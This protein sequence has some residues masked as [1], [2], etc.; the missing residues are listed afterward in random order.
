[1]TFE[2][3]LDTCV[4]D[5][6]TLCDTL[7]RI[8]ENGA[9]EPRWSAHVLVELTRN[10]V[11]I[12]SV[13]REGA[14]ARIT[15]MTHAFPNATVTAYA[16]LLDDVPGHPDDAHVMAAS[17]VSRC[18][19]IVTANLKDFPEP[20]LGQWGLTVSHP[21]A[22]LLDQLELHPRETLLALQNQSRESSRP[23]TVVTPAVGIAQTD[24]RPPIRCGGRTPT[25]PRSSR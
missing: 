2:I 8:A 16:Q 9:F 17:I 23:V 10:L 25:K 6:A 24:R 21:D 22:F 18:Q 5:P 19:V 4:L 20:D 13:G 15:A 14:Q 12:E 1:M 7:L 11:T 3:L